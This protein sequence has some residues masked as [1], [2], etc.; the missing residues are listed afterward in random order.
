MKMRPEQW[1]RGGGHPGGRRQGKQRPWQRG[2]RESELPLQRW[3]WSCHKLSSL[4]VMPWISLQC[5][6]ILPSKLP[7]ACN[8][9]S[10]NVSSQEN[11]PKLNMAIPRPASDKMEIESSIIFGIATWH[12][13]QNKIKQKNPS[14]RRSGWYWWRIMMPNVVV[15]ERD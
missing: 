7:R 15:P 3:L 4:A 1:Q 8:M 5:H 9:S 12:L 6:L 2:R 14:I 13:Q 10:W 11:T